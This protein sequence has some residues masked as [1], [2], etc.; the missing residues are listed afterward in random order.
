MKEW[1]IKHL[2]LWLARLTT[3]HWE[4]ALEAVRVAALRY[5]ELTGE[6][7]KQYVTD[8]LK[9]TWPA[10]SA[11]AANLLIELAY[12]FAKRRGYLNP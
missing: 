5:R 2:L 6:Q 9:L 11:G 10:L 12:A 4:A 8:T 3:D 7:R 1:L